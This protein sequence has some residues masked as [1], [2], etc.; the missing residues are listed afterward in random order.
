MEEK[1][2]AFVVVL[3]WMLDLNLSIVERT[4]YA[5]IYGFSQ[6]RMG[7]FTGSRAYLARW[8]SCTTRTVD[9][10]LAK[11]VS[12]GLLDKEEKY[13]GGV[14]LC[15][16][17]AKIPQR[18][19]FAGS[20]KISQGVAKKFRGGSEKISHNNIEY[21]GVNKLT[22]SI[23]IIGTRAREE[24]DDPF[25]WPPKEET[26]ADTPSPLPSPSPKTATRFTP[27]TLEE[28]AAYCRERGNHIDPQH[29][30]NYYSA[31][32]WM[33]GKNKMKDWRAAVRNWE[34]RDKERNNG[35]RNIDPGS[36]AAYRHLGK[37]DYYGESTI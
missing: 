34:T 36:P 26:P 17:A 8:C 14:K 28:V 11:L 5:T 9:T 12:V 25:A 19:N 20:E 21:N 6:K 23:E 33:V 7:K 16:Y 31:N 24:E 35:K 22:P 13:E 29:F 30:V 18:K 32:G 1:D 27:P 2:T 15:A 3:E 10:A 37:N 4:I